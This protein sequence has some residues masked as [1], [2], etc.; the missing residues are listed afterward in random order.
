MKVK[1]R[2]HG[3]S[4]GNANAQTE[5]DGEMLQASVPC[6]EVELVTVSQRHGSLMLRFTGSQIEEARELYKTDRSIVATFE[7]DDE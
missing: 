4:N 2:V 3:V 7:G 1:M 5:V 6:L